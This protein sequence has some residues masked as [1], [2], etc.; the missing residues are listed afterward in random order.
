MVVASIS[1]TRNA[2]AAQLPP[3]PKPR[4]ATPTRRCRAPR[5]RPQM[6][7]RGIGGPFKH[8]LQ[9]GGTDVLRN[10]WQTGG[11]AS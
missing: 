10:W 1:S 6:D 8:Y 5:R 3:A 9:S 7:N 11:S 2:T 4:A